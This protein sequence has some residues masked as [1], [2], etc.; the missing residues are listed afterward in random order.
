[1]LSCISQKM[2]VGLLIYK[3]LSNV[4]LDQLND[5]KEVCFRSLFDDVPLAK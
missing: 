4:N 2:V 1:M 5:I 3:S